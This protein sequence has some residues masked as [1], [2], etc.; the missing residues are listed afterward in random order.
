MG[1]ALT[2]QG[3]TAVG[4]TF[5]EA[6][7][8]RLVREAPSTFWA[9]TR[10]AGT[11]GAAALSATSATSPSSQATSSSPPLSVSS[12]LTLHFSLLI[13]RPRP[14]SHASWW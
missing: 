10:S 5:V 7:D 11:H 1:G 9:K 6:G 8:P 12:S 3:N 13:E 2:N 14:I 4:A